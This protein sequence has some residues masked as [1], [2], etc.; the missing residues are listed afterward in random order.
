VREMWFK[1]D[2]ASPVA[3]YLQIVEQFKLMVAQG[4]LVLGDR[5]PSVRELALGLEINP[6]T[7]ASAYRE[8]VYLGIV[9]S[10]K[11]V[12]LFIS[13]DLDKFTKKEKER[14]LNSKLEELF[15]FAM[16]LGYNQKEILESARSCAERRAR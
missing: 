13:D 8:L 15:D 10:K 14:Q 6:N 3:I 2:V 7:V 9:K 5:L 12:G 4:E 16:K 11:G 1:V